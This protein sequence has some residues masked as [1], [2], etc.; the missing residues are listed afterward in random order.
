MQV[1][2]HNHCAIACLHATL[3]LPVN[4]MK[5][6]WDR[7]KVKPSKDN[8]HVTLVGYSQPGTGADPGEWRGGEGLGVEKTLRAFA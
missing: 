4:I 8:K 3:R 5:Y 7:V 6:K 1:G 2:F